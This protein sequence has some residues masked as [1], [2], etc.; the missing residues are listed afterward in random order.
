LKDKPGKYPDIYHTC[1]SLSGMSSAISKV[2]PKLYEDG[3][4]YDGKFK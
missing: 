1:Y 3:Q 2:N 4:T